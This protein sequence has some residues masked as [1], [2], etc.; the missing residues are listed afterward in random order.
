[1]EARRAQRKTAG[2]T[3][4][5]RAENNQLWQTD[6][7]RPAEIG[8]TWRLNASKTKLLFGWI[9]VLVNSGFCA[10]CFKVKIAIASEGAEVEFKAI[11]S[12]TKFG[13][14]AGS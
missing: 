7:K 10:T 9:G 2:V 13:R 6:A 14:K 3:E 4:G 5:K 1:M 12:T 11:R 8:I